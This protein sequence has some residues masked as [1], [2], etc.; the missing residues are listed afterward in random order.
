LEVVTLSVADVNR[1]RAFYSERVGFTVDVDYQPTAEFRVVQLTPPGSA[2]VSLRRKARQIPVQEKSKSKAKTAD[3]KL[4]LHRG[5]QCERRQD[6][7]R[8][9]VLEIVHLDGGDA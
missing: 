9:F 4:R 8:P 5:P 7:G 1:A 3:S 2:P 6:S